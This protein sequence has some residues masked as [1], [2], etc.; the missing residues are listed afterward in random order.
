MQHRPQL[1]SPQVQQAYANHIP[2]SSSAAA[3]KEAN[4]IGCQ[5][6]ESFFFAQNLFCLGFFKSNG[7]R[8]TIDPNPSNRT[9]DIAFVQ[10]EAL[11][12][13]VHFST[14]LAAIP[15]IALTFFLKLPQLSPPASTLTPVDADALA[16]TLAA[17]AAAPITTQ[18]ITQLFATGG[19]IADLDL[20]N[21]AV[22]SALSALLTSVSSPAT[23]PDPLLIS[24]PTT[25]LRLNRCCREGP[26]IIVCQV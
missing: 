6:H 19:T 24:T 13:P 7:K 12:T 23:T 15:P 25:S 20:T 21:A 26:R 8:T 3:S 1:S 10:L 5:L 9:A 16:A 4:R 17:S 22:A 14:G 2:V 18:D 11:V